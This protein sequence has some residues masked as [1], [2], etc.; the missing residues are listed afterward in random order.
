MFVALVTVAT[1]VVQIPVAATQGYVNFG[2]SM[3]FLCAYFLGPIP[4]LIAGAVGSGLADL[5]V[6]PVWAPFTIVIKGLEGLLCGLLFRA[7]G[8][9]NLNKVGKYA[10][11]LVGMILSACWMVLGY[12]FAGWI[13]TGN[14]AA[15]LTDVPA[16]FVQ[17]GVSVAITFALIFVCKLPVLL[18]KTDKKS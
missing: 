18:Q 14:A 7:F 3:I 5:F 13:L 15:S 12:F 10:L 9:F 2:D 4:A 17:G 8:K 1:M 11:N 6:A 16:T